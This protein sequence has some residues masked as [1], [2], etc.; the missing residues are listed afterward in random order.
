MNVRGPAGK[1]SIEKRFDQVFDKMNSEQTPHEDRLKLIS[2]QALEEVQTWCKAPTTS[3]P[4]VSES[5]SHSQVVDWLIGL[6]MLKTPDPERLAL[7]RTA[8]A[9]LKSKL[10]PSYHD[11]IKK[12]EIGQELQKTIDH[13]YDTELCSRVRARVPGV[14]KADVAQVEEA[15]SLIW[16]ATQADAV[17]LAALQKVATDLDFDPGATTLLGC[18]LDGAINKLK[19]LAAE[20][21]DRE[22][23]QN[24]EPLKTLTVINEAEVS[25]AIRTALSKVAGYELRPMNAGE[26]RGLLA[27][28]AQQTDENVVDILEALRSVE[29]Q[30]D[31]QG[32]NAVAAGVVI[33]ALRNT[34]RILT[35][36]VK[37]HYPDKKALIANAVA[38]ESQIKT[39]SSA[40][41][42]S[43][44]E[45]KPPSV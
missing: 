31:L 45:K 43:V 35:E 4:G 38:A 25:D 29:T 40:D 13:L 44:V 20:A 16:G 1:N 34:I 6:C 18:L 11:L 42:D 21:A 5:A 30:F 37:K 27:Q 41:D 12:T 36:T 7:L 23:S 26:I 24:F 17:T 39:V 32:Q 22:I 10:N 19:A 9:S 15:L 14:D 3:T 8:M 2:S 28:L 33:G